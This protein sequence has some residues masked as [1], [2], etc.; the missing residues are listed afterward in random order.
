MT[1]PNIHK[2]ELCNENN[3]D[4]CPN[5]GGNGIIVSFDHVNDEKKIDGNDTHELPIDLGDRRGL[6]A[7]VKKL[8]YGF[9]AWVV[10]SAADPNND[11]PK[12]YDVQVPFSTWGKACLLIPPNAVPNSFG[13]FRFE[14][15]GMSID[16]W[17]GELGWIFQRPS[18][19]WAWHPASGIFITKVKVSK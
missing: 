3:R 10:G 14:D 7:I 4:S 18:C 2:C 15:E 16:V 11:D 9:D 13:G 1:V 12:D 17:P 8:T 5:C 6:P 19:R